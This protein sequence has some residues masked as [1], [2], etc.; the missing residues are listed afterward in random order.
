MKPAG[1]R[2]SEMS[3]P[4]TMMSVRLDNPLKKQTFLK[5]IGPTG[6]KVKGSRERN[7]WSWT[8]L[9][10]KDEHLGIESDYNASPIVQDGACD[11]PIHYT[12][13]IWLQSA[14]HGLTAWDPVSK[15]C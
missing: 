11:T 6:H 8:R 9:P 4:P 2:M 3:G 10:C 1:S 7:I 13:G 12:E 15:D 14:W 5:P